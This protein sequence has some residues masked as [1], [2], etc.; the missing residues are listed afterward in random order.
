M[1]SPRL[2]S[3]RIV[4]AV[5]T[6]MLLLAPT[7]ALPRPMA[8]R[9]ASSITVQIVDFAFEP[10]M[11]MIERGTTVTW[12]NV[13]DRPHTVTADD[14]TFDSGRLDPGEQFNFTFDEPGTFTYVCGFHPEMQGTLMVADVQSDDLEVAIPEPGGEPAEAAADNNASVVSLLSVAQQDGLTAALHTGDCADLGPEVAALEAASVP[15][16]AR[17]GSSRSL[18]GANSFTTI[19]VALDAMLAADHALVIAGTDGETLACGEVGGYLTDAGALIVGFRPGP[20]TGLGGVAFLSPADVPAQTNVS[21]FL[22]GEALGGEGGE[23]AAPPEATG[24][25]PAQPEETPAASDD[26]TDQLQVAQQPTAVP[27]EKPEPTPTPVPLGASQ[28]NPAPLGTTLQSQGLAVT[29]ESAYFDAGFANA[30]P[31]GGY[32]VLILGV[33]IA[34]ESDED[35]GYDASRFFGIDATTGNTY[36]PVTIDDVGVLLT[37]GTLQPG[38]FVSGTALIEVQETATSVIVKYDGDFL[39]DEEDLYWS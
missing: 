8:A 21:L 37:D 18:P 32:K 14:G 26:A 34:N 13:G 20:S 38:E 5:L 35:R 10:A 9:Q 33:T 7:I 11:V 1:S 19:P 27:T 31:R 3:P 4:L 17:V 25:A 36:D 28:A 2:R 12:T 16:G 24:V 15:S 6:A 39:G 29:V 23:A 22:T 30:I